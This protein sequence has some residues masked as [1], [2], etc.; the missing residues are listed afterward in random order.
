LSAGYGCERET[1]KSDTLIFV[2]KPA[3]VYEIMEA[4]EKALVFTPVS[5]TPSVHREQGEIG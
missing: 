1:S 2:E 4:I 5:Y 3:G